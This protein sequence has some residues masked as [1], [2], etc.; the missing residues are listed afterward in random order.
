MSLR[1]TPSRSAP[2]PRAAERKPDGVAVA[3][4][5]TRVDPTT[6]TPRRFRVLL[7]DDDY[8]TMDFVVW[9]LESFF[10]HPRDQ[11]IR[12]ML[13]VHFQG[14]T[15]AGIFPLE[16]AETKVAEVTA[17]SEQHG[18]PLRAT[19]EPEEGSD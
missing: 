10:Q 2:G 1:P 11:A 5:Q 19:A 13:E 15:V 12:L 9:V 16:V 7:H 6:K 18:M 17:A 8:T 3:T 4:P 14:V